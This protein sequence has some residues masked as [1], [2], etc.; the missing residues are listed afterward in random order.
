MENHAQL[1]P[2]TYDQLL[3]WRDRIHAKYLLA[4]KA[5]ADARR[6]ERLYRRYAKRHLLAMDKQ[7]REAQSAQPS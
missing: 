3:V 1:L 2:L 6:H 5:L 7:Q 4:E